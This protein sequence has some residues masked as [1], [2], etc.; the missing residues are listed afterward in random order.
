MGQHGGIHRAGLG[1][2]EQHRDA[3]GQQDAACRCHG[4]VKEGTG[5]DGD[6]MGQPRDAIGQPGD[7]VGQ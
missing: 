3:M 7:A 4:S 6:A 5:K 2:R 1:A